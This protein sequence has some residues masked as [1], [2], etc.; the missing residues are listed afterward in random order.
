[1][2]DCLTLDKGND[3]LKFESQDET[4]VYAGKTGFICFKASGNVIGFEEGIV[5]LTIGQFRKVIKNAEELIAEAEENKR[6][7]EAENE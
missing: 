6:L 4:Q 5:M 3:M 1:M 2:L 7:Y